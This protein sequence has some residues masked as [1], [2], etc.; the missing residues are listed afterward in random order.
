MD[1]RS[2]LETLN[3]FPASGQLQQSPSTSFVKIEGVL[4]NVR[5]FILK[6]V[7]EEVKVLQSPYSKVIKL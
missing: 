7:F 5:N 6:F 4:L 2:L 1:M 3:S